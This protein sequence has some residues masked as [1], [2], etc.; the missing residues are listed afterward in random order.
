VLSLYRY[1]RREVVASVGSAIVRPGG[2]ADESS[3]GDGRAGRGA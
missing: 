3:Q 1:D 2:E